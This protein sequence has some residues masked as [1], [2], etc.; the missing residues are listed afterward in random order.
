MKLRFNLIT[1]D[2]SRT[3]G[4]RQ[5]DITRIRQVCRL[6]ARQFGVSESVPELR[7]VGQRNELT[8]QEIALGGDC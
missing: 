7:T 1:E 2:P 3:N 4:D 8:N 5:A 6:R